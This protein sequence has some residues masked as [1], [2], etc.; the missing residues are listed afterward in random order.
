MQVEAMQVEAPLPTSAAG[1]AAAG[2]SAAHAAA[3]APVDLSGVT[4]RF[5]A[6]QSDSED[7]RQNPPP[8]ADGD[9][10]EADAAASRV[11]HW[12]HLRFAVNLD[13]K[14]ERRVRNVVYHEALTSV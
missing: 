7:D 11:G 6:D 10:D 1:A 13:E 14:G 2:T 4:N 3:G 9:S 8:N 5:L 12:D